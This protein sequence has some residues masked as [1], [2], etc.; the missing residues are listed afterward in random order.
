MKRKINQLV[1]IVGSSGNGFTIANVDVEK[2]ILKER[3]TLI[4]NKIQLNCFSTI[5]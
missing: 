1:S 4:L 5:A 3:K 2:M